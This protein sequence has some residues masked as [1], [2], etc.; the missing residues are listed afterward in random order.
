MWK[1]EPIGLPP[2]LRAGFTTSQAP[3]DFQGERFTFE[4][5]AH[6]ESR[7]SVLSRRVVTS[8]CGVDD[9]SWRDVHQVH[10]ANVIECTEESLGRVEAD[11]LWTRH[12][13][14]VLAIRT[15]DCVP[16]IVASWTDHIIAV[17]HAG[18]RGT[19]KNIVGHTLDAIVAATGAELGSF[20]AV[21]GPCIHAHAFEVDADVA[22]P[23]Q[24][25]FE[26]S[27]VERTPGKDSRWNVDLVQANSR[28]LEACG[29]SPERIK[30]LP[31][32]TVHDS[33]FWSHRRQRA[34][35]GRQVAFACMEPR[36]ETPIS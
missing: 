3:A 22:V 32:C 9:D 14:L 12:S 15:A 7:D 28:Q 13:G 29:L 31:M 30:A 1:V 27:V 17:I 5:K 21:I 24:D 33:R 34:Q 36:S 20:S 11:A 2:S 16:I 19:H 26:H 10:G 25:A 8:F 23:F 6:T 18:W 4:P 35:A